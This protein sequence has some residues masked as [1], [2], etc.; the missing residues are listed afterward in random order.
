[1]PR[2]PSQLRES[3]LSAAIEVLKE[4]GERSLTQ[5]KVAAAAGIPQGH[6]TYY[7]PKKR[8]LLIGVA[9]RFAELTAKDAVAAL[10][11]HGDRPSQE[12]LLAHVAQL[13]KDHSRTRMLLGL[14]VLADGE[15]ELAEV[16]QN[17]AKMLRNMM[18]AALQLETDDM[19][20]DLIL[21]MLWGLGLHE[22]VFRAGRTDELAPR[23]LNLLRQKA[24]D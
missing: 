24:T 16:M 4:K 6:L 19:L 7:F 15:P 1:M 12:S 21:A 14:L 8:D 23:A 9:Q 5:T 20:V 3:I 10:T 13:S 2:P 11:Q 22:F 17:N 18:A